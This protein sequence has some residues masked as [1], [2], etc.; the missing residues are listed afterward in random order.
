VGSFPSGH[1][2]RILGFATV[3]W[4]AMPH[5]RSVHAFIVF[6]GGSMLVSLVAMNYHFVSDVIAGGALGGIIATYAAQLG[7]LQRV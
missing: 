1:A 6:M 5:S 4:I 2:A 7:R 3:W